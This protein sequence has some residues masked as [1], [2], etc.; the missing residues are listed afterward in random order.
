MD[1]AITNR[2]YLFA[3]PLALIML[4]ALA[5]TTPNID[6][7]VEARAKELVAEQVNNLPPDSD[8]AID[9]YNSALGYEKTGD[10]QLAIGDYTK[11][12]NLGLPIITID[13]SKPLAAAYFNRAPSTE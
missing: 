1:Y 5:C 2:A 7:T 3:I 9:H 12:I 10:W 8:L 13:G 11:A 6:A 4:M